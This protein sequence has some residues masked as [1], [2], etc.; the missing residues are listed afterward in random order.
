MVI[1]LRPHVS[2]TNLKKSYITPP[3]AQSAEFDRP[4]SSCQ[5]QGFEEEGGEEGVR[6]CLR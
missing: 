2:V 1:K 6:G 5:R 4:K 3:T